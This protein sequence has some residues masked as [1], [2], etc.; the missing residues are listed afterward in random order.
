MRGGE[1]SDEESRE[2]VEEGGEGEQQSEAPNTEESVCGASSDSQRPS[3]ASHSS[4]LPL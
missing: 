2:A 3:E 1:K 4:E